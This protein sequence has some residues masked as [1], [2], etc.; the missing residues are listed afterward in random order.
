MLRQQQT[1]VVNGFGKQ[2]QKVF[3]GNAVHLPSV[4]KTMQSGAG[5]DLALMTFNFTKR[6]VI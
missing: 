3:L 4:S 6:Y 5:N 2:S 1:T